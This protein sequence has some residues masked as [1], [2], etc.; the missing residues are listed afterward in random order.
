M[1]PSEGNNDVISAL[2]STTLETMPEEEEK[3]ENV[4]DG[5]TMVTR[6]RRTNR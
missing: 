4:D 3:T 2:S 6:S 1:V 5:W